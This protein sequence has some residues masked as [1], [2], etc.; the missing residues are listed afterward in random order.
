MEERRAERDKRGIIP[1]EKPA[2]GSYA[3]QRLNELR[4]DREKYNVNF[5]GYY[6]GGL[7]NPKMGPVRGKALGAPGDFH[8]PQ[9]HNHIEYLS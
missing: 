5:L 3:E 2:R 1:S 8:S 4:K 9:I 7:P 6:K